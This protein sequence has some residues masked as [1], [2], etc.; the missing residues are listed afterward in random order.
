MKCKVINKTKD[1]ESFI[2]VA[3]SLANNIKIISF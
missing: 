3:V 1:C 2:D